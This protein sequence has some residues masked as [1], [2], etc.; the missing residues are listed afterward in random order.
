M[1]FLF[2]CWFFCSHLVELLE[3]LHKAGVA[4]PQGVRLDDLKFIS[5]ADASRCW[6]F[7]QGKAAERVINSHW[8]CHPLLQL[9]AMIVR[10]KLVRGLAGT[11]VCLTNLATQLHMEEQRGIGDFHDLWAQVEPLTVG[12]ADVL[13]SFERVHVAGLTDAHVTT[14]TAATKK[15][16]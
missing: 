7:R 5:V 16:K 6:I 1:R 8:T 14:M 3:V 9:T 11:S 13:P 15:R 4:L 10:F 2:S 12:V